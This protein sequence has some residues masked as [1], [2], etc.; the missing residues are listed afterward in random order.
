MRRHLPEG[1][2]VTLFSDRSL[3]SN[4]QSSMLNVTEEDVEKMT[5]EAS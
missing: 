4:V 1:A 2:R 5:N 3:H